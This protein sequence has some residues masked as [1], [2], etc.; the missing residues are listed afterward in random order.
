MYYPDSLDEE[1]RELLLLAMLNWLFERDP[2][3]GGPPGFGGHLD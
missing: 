1:R 2:S 3:P